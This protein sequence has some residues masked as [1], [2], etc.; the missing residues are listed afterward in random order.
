[1]KSFY[2]AVLIG[3][4]AIYGG[5]AQARELQ[6]KCD[7]EHFQAMKVIE[8][9]KQLKLE[10]DA[11]K[12]SGESAELLNRKIRRYNDINNSSKLPWSVTKRETK[13]F[14]AVSD[15]SLA[16]NRTL[17]CETAKKEKKMGERTPCFLV[18]GKVCTDSFGPSLSPE[19]SHFD[20]PKFVVSPNLASSEMLLKPSD[21][22]GAGLKIGYVN[23]QM[24]LE[25]V[26]SSPDDVKKIYAHIQLVA[27]KLKYGMVL[28]DV[29][30]VDRGA[31][32]TDS[33]IKSMQGVAF[34]ENESGSTASTD[35]RVGT[36]HVQNIAS[37]IGTTPAD[38][39]KIK[40][41]IK[42][43]AQKFGL[44]LVVQVFSFSQGV[45]ITEHVM[46]SIN[47]QPFS[48][49]DLKFKPVSR[50]KLGFI[51]AEKAHQEFPD[52]AASA[53][54]LEKEFA[55]RAAELENMEKQGDNDS[56]K[57]FRQDLIKD[58]QT[59]QKEDL[60]LISAKIK[61]TVN[62]LGTVN[63]FDIIVY[64]AV[65]VDPKLDITNFVLRNMSKAYK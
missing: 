54:Q 61:S 37:A 49:G 48:D 23:A 64:D 38:S 9:K 35:F 26:G 55:A 11:G 53:R 58:V 25:K 15:G 62:S 63:L 47:G 19:L 40:K 52:T 6:L 50:A 57:K 41:H 31:D 3:L 56:V 29:A 33:V 2:T 45:D 21:W 34:G 16:E 24:L 17:L 13:T 59:R 60:A 46:K 14:A 36:V 65:H 32:I 4:A 43:V 18:W 28:Q 39:E 1:V 22:S 10:I 30:Y 5:G 51:S 12:R 42:A 20:G 7:D 44:G 27:Q 8:E